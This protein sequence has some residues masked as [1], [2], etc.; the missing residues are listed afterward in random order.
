MK[1][2]IK[3]HV[4]YLFYHTWFPL[5]LLL[6]MYYYHLAAPCG[7][8]DPGIKLVFPAMEAWSS[9]HWTIREFPP[10]LF[11]V[12]LLKS[13][14]NLNFED[15]LS[16]TKMFTHCGGSQR[17]HL[18][19]PRQMSLTNTCFSVRLYV[20]K[21]FEKQNLEFYEIKLFSSRIQE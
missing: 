20:F 9:S 2:E 21:Y 6:L 12:G 17:S 8:Q 16:W 13:Q 14:W 19:A 3:G 5:L 15:I 18:S 11:F 7:L 4:S 10:I 1:L